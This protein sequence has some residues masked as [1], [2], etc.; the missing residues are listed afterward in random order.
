MRRAVFV[1]ISLVLMA[2]PMATRGQPLPRLAK[3]GWLSTG[4]IEVDAS[5]MEG[6][7]AG[8]KDLGYVENKHFA[9]E[10]R[11]TGGDPERLGDAARELV[12]LNVDVI[13][14]SGDQAAL[15]AKRA[16]A[17]VPVLVQVADATGIGLVKNMARPGGNITGFN[18]L[19]ADLVPKRLELLKEL[20]PKLL[21]ATFISNPANPT[22]VQQSR[23][24]IAAAPSFGIAMSTTEI[25][26]PQDVEPAFRAMTKARAEAFIVCGDRMLGTQ[27]ARIYELATKTRL[28]GMYANRRFVDSGG[29]MSYGTNLADVYRGLAVYL[30]K[31]LK[32]SKSGDLPMQQPTKFE[33]ALNLSAAK[34][35]GFSIPDAMRLRADYVID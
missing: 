14:A 24:V 28:L 9:I 26:G 18:D 4:S 8:L 23:Q 29:L 2:G 11:I 17:S 10:P 21:R 25:R 7:R 13:V 31:I 33:I 34:A 3:V 12:G 20:S 27:R 30:D 6:L 16:T 15:A 19:H 32:G 1:L 22:C 5:L 35:I